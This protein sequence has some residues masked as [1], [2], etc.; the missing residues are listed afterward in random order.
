MRYQYFCYV[1]I[2]AFSSA[3]AQRGDSLLLNET[4][5]SRP[6]N[7]HHR[8]LRIS[9]AHLLALSSTQ[10]IGNKNLSSIETGRT[11]TFTGIDLDF[12]Y[13][14]TEHLQARLLLKR[15]AEVITEPA[16]FDG[17][18]TNFY[19]FNSSNQKIGWLD[20]EYWLDFRLPFLGRRSDVVF[21]VGY[22]L[23][24]MPSG[25]EKPTIRISSS[26]LN[27]SDG[28]EFENFST[29]LYLNAGNGVPRFS[30][31]V[32]LKHRFKRIAL[33]FQSTYYLPLGT[34]TLDRWV[35]SD[36][37]TEYDS[38][39]FQRQLADHLALMAGVEMQVRPWLNIA[40]EGNYMQ[41]RHGWNQ[42]KDEKIL[43]P[44]ATLTQLNFTYEILASKRLWLG[45][46]LY[47]NIDGKDVFAPL[48]LTTFV[49]YNL[50]L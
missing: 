21:N 9:G 24:L 5:L 40:I 33:N 1:F 28:S 34:E 26:T 6:L 50:F 32:Q 22:S 47:V 10:Y 18:G 12:K 43:V 41:S 35:L 46:S 30:Y 7:V 23:P 20:P 16:F 25:L 14:I 45:Q 44:T 49:N 37:G 2:F 27:F 11:R 29:D 15:V 42:Q 8:Q 19:I 4:K 13:G 38:E 48:L 36:N 31:G 17:V 39:S 3:Y